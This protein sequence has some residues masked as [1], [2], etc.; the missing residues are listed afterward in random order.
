MRRGRCVQTHRAE[1]SGVIYAGIHIDAPAPQIGRGNG[2]VVVHT[3]NLGEA[4]EALIGSALD[5]SDQ[6]RTKAAG[7]LGISVRTLRSKLN[8]PN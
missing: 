3:L 1:R 5:A 6:N 2:G 4:E 7:L 8:R